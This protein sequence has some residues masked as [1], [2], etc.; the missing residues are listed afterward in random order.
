MISWTIRTKLSLWYT[1]IFGGMLFLFSLLTYV[2]FSHANN[3]RIDVGL[4]EEAV[5]IAH[6]AQ[7]NMNSFKEYVSQISNERDEEWAAGKY[8]A[9]LGPAGNLQFRSG[10][11]TDAH[12]PLQ[13]HQIKEI[14]SGKIYFKTV[15]NSKG[16]LL[17][18]ITIPIKDTRQ[19]IQIGIV[20]NKDTALN[21]FLLILTALGFLAIVGSWLG[22][23]FMAKKALRPIDCMIKDLQ[24]IETEHLGKRLVIH[25]VKDE[26]SELS[27]VINE[28]LT[29][30]ENSFSQ[31]RQFTTDASHELRTPIAIMKAGIEVALSSERDICSYQQILA[32]TLEDLGRFSKI[33]ESL[34]ILAKADAGQYELQKKRMNLHPVVMDIAEQLKLIAEPKNIFVSM[35]KMEDAFIDGDELLI[36]MMLLNL[37]DNAVK[38]TQA[39]GTIKLSLYKD[40]GCVKI[41]IRDNGIGISQEDL[42]RIFDRFYRACKVRTANHTSSGLGLSICQWIVKSHHGTII[43]NSE[44]HKGST[45]TVTLPTC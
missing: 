22:G 10:N 26:I 31:V 34:F 2:A 25:P 14:F 4:T 41:S 20:I 1:S 24:K 16:R 32:N 44:L 39:N 28:M 9:I 27:G 38:Y 15:K 21:I 7:I 35:E 18:I 5:G 12:L 42:P 43:V 11:L 6:H 23:R 40:N 30:L 8:I 29:R 17:R 37:I 13:R 45:F 36:R 33:I 3:K 19:L